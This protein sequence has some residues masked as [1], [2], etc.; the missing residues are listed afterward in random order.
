[1][2]TTWVF[3]IAIG[4]L[5]LAVVLVL[6]QKKSS[7]SS[8]K[9]ASVDIDLYLL[10][11]KET[12]LYN[13]RFFAKRIQEEIHRYHRYHSPF[14]LGLLKLPPPVASKDDASL[15]RFMRHVGAVIEK[16]TRLTDVISRFGREDVGVLFS[17]TGQRSAE[18]P[19]YRIKEKINQ[20]LQEE[21][22]GEEARFV[23]YSYPE[24]ARKIDEL[25]EKLK[26]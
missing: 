13:Q 7:R 20:L 5:I 22:I 14:S 6:L 25:V 17:M 19:I 15:G 2:S 11:D 18:V 24:D 9:T 21:G 16:D 26:L 1:M 12:G 8:A 3:L 23:V 4:I 10:V